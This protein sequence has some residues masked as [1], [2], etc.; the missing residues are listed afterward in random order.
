MK[1]IIIGGVAGGATAAA[2][3]R[4]ADES[5]E[6]ILLE[7]GKYISY[8][9]CGLPYYIGGVIAER[10]KLFLQTPHSFG[11]RFNMEVRVEN[12]VI[13]VDPEKKTVRVRKADGSE[14]TENYDKLLLSPGATPVRP[15]LEGI[16][17]D[18][19]FTLRD[20]NDTD[21]I[22][23]YLTTH[24]VKKAVVVGA[25]FIGL[26]MAENLHHTGAEVSIVE[27]GN[28][29]MAPIDFSMAAEVHQHL[30]LKG[31]SLYLEQS[32]ER[33]SQRGN[34]IDVHFKSGEV[35]PADIVIL[36]I[37]VRPSTALAK[38]AG[39]K[40]GETGGI[41]VDEYL[42]TSAKDIYAVGDAIEFPHPITGKPW[43]NY[44]A[45]PA[46]RQGRIV[47]DNMAFGNH[48]K[49]KGAIGTSIA[50][51]FDMT[52]ASTGLAAKRLKQLDIPYRSSWT[53]S[54]SHA[55][56]YPDALP[57]SLKLTFDPQSGKLYGGQCVGYEGVDK[58]IDQIAQLI[59]NGGS[60]YDLIETE[61]TYAPPFSSAKDPIAIA[62]Y[63]ASNII[64]GAMP[65]LTW[66]EM[67]SANRDEVVILDV[68]TKDEF[69]MGAIPGATHIPLEELRSRIT[70]IPT[71]K[72]ILVY[73]AVGIRGY[74]ATK[75]LMGRGFANVRNLLGGY[76]RFMLA[77]TPV[78]QADATAPHHSFSDNKD[79]NNIM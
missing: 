78:K 57:L 41:W 20:V 22:K 44:L 29:V 62:G 7:K 11:E 76:E 28:Q 21:R 56:Y 3:I 6:I 66:R 9:N 13:A 25:G 69:L 43:L 15:P 42:E 61:H 74:V 34:Q 33:F 14:Y 23:E 65:A 48:T 26:E 59:K 51:V 70:E 35:I 38:E 60:V 19:I 54:A 72:P 36:S 12:E 31:V 64:S 37:G 46:N 16:D 75:I 17:S 5:A 58:R 39:L 32:V 79:N 30:L 27:M 53:H 63:V 40:I 67:Q 49:Y 10:E 18:G 68:R 47:A 77:T 55:G 45:N 8:A 24:P 2:R 52:V 50:K 4:R 71:D 1:H 73:C